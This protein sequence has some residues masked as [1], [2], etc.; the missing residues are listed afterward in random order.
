MF[1]NFQSETVNSRLFSALENLRVFVIVFVS[2]LFALTMSNVYNRNVPHIL[3]V[4]I[5]CKRIY[6]IYSVT[7][8]IKALS[9]FSTIHAALISLTPF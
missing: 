5:F 8:D 2:Y 1:P 4:Y 7:C 9:F 6:L 3:L